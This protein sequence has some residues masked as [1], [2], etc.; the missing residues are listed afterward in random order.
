VFPEVS[1]TK[2]GTRATDVY[3][4]DLDI[5]K[6]KRVGGFDECQDLLLVCY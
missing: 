1:P 4:G 2:R 6:N 5:D 3:S